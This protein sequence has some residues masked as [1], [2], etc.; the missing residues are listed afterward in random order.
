MTGS[1]KSIR[2]MSG[3]RSIACWSASMP[4]PASM[5]SK[6]EYCRYSLYISRASG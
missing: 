3:E 2:M 1:D 5:T 6:P 4:L